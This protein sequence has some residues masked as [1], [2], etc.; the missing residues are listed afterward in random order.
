MAFDYL[1]GWAPY[2]SSAQRR[3][4]AELAR[5]RLAKELGR[6]ASPVVITGRRIA[7]TFWGQAWCQNLE[8]YSD[9]A[10]RLPRGRSYLRNGCV[11]DLQIEPGTV[12]ARVSGTSLYTVQ[13][14]VAALPKAKWQ[15]ICRDVA[16]AIDSVIELLQG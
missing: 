11:V 5:K 12:T 9:F 8:R 16:G 1:Y 13:I 6:P 10:T 14:D 3:R 15:A 7:T 4:Q 2:V